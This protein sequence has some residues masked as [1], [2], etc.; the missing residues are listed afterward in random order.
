MRSIDSYTEELRTSLT[1]RNLDTSTIQDI[2][3]EVS[4]ECSSYEQAMTQFGTPDAYAQNYE[5]RQAPR[6]G[7]IFTVISVIAAII[8]IVVMH[9]VRDSE[10][11]I[12]ANLAVTY[13]PALS[14]MVLGI[15][16]DFSRFQAR[17]RH[18]R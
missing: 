14:L 10:T 2:I 15:I 17:V 8:W 12:L 3:R 7:T 9:I 1:L 13:L 5:E 16:V 11:N 18:T 4:S 6:G